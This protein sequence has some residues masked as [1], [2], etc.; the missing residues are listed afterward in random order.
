LIILSFRFINNND[1]INIKISDSV[2]KLVVLS[3]LY[4]IIDL[5]SLIYVLI[6]NF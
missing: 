1:N 6:R 2:G 5:L 3:G 4:I